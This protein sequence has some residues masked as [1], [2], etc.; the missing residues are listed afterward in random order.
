MVFGRLHF[1]LE[2]HISSA[3]DESSGYE[4]TGG[5]DGGRY[6]L[7]PIPNGPIT[8]S[9]CLGAALRYFVGGSPYN[10]MCVFGISYSEVLA[11]VWIELLMR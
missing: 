4:C 11:S 10:I 6:S 8:P 2:P 5:R 9:I 3:I 1:T 7:P